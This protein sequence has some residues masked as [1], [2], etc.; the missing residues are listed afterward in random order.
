VNVLVD[1]YRPGVLER[2]VDL[3]AVAA[4]RG[5]A[6]TK[7][8]LVVVRLTGYGQHSPLA[9]HDLNYIAK[10]G[11]LSALGTEG[12]PPM[13]PINVLGD[14]AALAL[15]AFAA[16][17]VALYGHASDKRASKDGNGNNN[18]NK[19]NYDNDN[20]QSE[21]KVV[22]VDV[23]IVE[24]LRYLAQFVTFA[25]YHTETA[26]YRSDAP[27]GQNILDGQACPFYTVYETANAGEYI[28]VGAL[29][30][31]FYVS[32]LDFL[33]IKAGG[34]NNNDDENENN[35]TIEGI[36][37]ILPNRF[38]RANWPLL[39][40][41]FQHRLKQQPL[42][43][44]AARAS[45]FPNACVMPVAPLAPPHLIPDAIVTGFGNPTPSG[46]EPQCPLGSKTPSKG[47][48]GSKSKNAVTEKGRIL[49][50]GAH[51]Y[52]VLAE[53]LGPA[54]Q[55]N[56]GAGDYVYQHKESTL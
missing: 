30:P 14:F 29:E 31:Q 43:Y 49:A 3:D 37:Q 27:R 15:P 11:L 34:R 24:S 4:A 42:S 26:M 56:Y 45:R 9:G 35:K 55:E 32:F 23:N 7:T 19:N 20:A 41:L 28:S 48:G 53:F 21:Q 22:Q 40:A 5:L 18:N 8:P 13:P 52:M 10:A 25:R 54:W 16:V 12:T 44:W 47:P 51:S 1:T 36:A 38:D 6:A 33:G 2:I 50:P 17:L 39:R 46:K